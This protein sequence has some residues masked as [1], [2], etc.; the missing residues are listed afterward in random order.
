[1]VRC[2]P[3]HWRRNFGTGSPAR[4]SNIAERPNRPRVRSMANQHAR[5]KCSVANP[6]GAAYLVARN[7]IVGVVAATN[8]CYIIRTFRCLYEWQRIPRICREFDWLRPFELT[9]RLE[10]V[11]HRELE[12][13][14]AKIGRA[15]V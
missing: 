13:Q 14:A 1:M 2:S 3:C 10:A 12:S 8:V 15:H 7:L 4:R 6:A 11:R 9:L 5:R